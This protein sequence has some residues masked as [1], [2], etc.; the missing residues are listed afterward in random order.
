MALKR[1][2]DGIDRWNQVALSGRFGADLMYAI[3]THCA[4][5]LLALAALINAQTKTITAG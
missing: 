4:L 1:V 2:D 3:H 5:V